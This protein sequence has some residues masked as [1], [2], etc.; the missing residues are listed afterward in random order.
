MN[1][2]DVVFH[3]IIICPEIT[4]SLKALSIDIKH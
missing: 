1:G 3:K 4:H 2:L